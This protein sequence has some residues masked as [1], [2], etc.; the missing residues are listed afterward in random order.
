MSLDI[1]L[2]LL[3]GLI[4]LI[5]FVGIVLPALPGLPLVFAGMLLAAWVGDFQHIGLATVVTLGILAVLA[6]GLDLL[7]GVVGAQRVGA[8][9][10]GLL[11]AALGA[12]AGLF[13]GIPGLIIGPFIGATVGEIAHGRALD[14]ASRVGLGTWIGMI[15]GAVV[16]LGLGGLMLGIFVLALVI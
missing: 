10:K 9:G 7:A 4:A 14:V 8:S 1:V 2:Y 13:F 3:A 16:K 15:I 11:G 5:G 12:V 6:Q